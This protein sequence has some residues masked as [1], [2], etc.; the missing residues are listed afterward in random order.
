MYRAA[1][2][3][4]PEK[5][6]EIRD[7]PEP[8]MEP[9]S[10]LLSTIYSEVCG[11][12]VHLHHGRLSGVPYPIIP[13]HVSVGR[14]SRIEGEITDVEGEIISEGD[15]VAFLDVH[16]TCGSCWFCLVA[17]ATTR[18]PSR[19]VYG[20]TYSADEGLLGGWS[21]AIYLKPGVKVIKLPQELTAERYIAAGCGLPT[22]THALERAE[23][24]L[25]DTV[26][27]Q[28]C[29]PVGLNTAVMAQI[30]GATEVIV[31]GAPQQRLDMAR[32]IGA[33]HTINIEEHG[34]EE[35]IA[36]VRELTGQRGADITIEA[37]GNPA[38][39]PEG[40]RMTRDLGRYVVVG[41]YTDA[42]PVEINP[43]RDINRKHLEIRGCWG[44]D[45]SHFYRGI[46]VLAKHGDRFPY[47][48]FITRIYRLEE[49]SE[50]LADVESLGVVK[51]AVQP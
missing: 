39:I 47:E 29:G 37:T 28:G 13:G 24:R 32:A 26:V 14:V 42:G 43:H 17:K 21:E 38:A 31:V 19:R 2:M 15:I 40:M 44:S 48:A 11:T 45:F 27:I 34:P 25:G 5:P 16:E 10:I 41:Q 33:D 3:V 20:I 18:C 12:D 1:V 36:L 51:A 7:Y 9:R 6:L 23:V 4:A 35:R 30:S 46:K 50:A 8:E 49:M 22:A